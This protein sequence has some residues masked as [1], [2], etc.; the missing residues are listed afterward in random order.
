MDG[1]HQA[2]ANISENFWRYKI[3]GKFTTL[4]TTCLIKSEQKQQSFFVSISLF[5]KKL[6]TADHVT[7][8]VSEGQ[9]TAPPP[10]TTSQGHQNTVTKYTCTVRSRNSIH[11]K[12]IL[13]TIY[14]CTQTHRLNKSI[15]KPLSHPP[16]H[17][18][19]HTGSINQSINQ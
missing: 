7:I 15:N 1:L 11:T 6:C 8:S 16:H 19:R 14:K 10:P 17:L 3:S 12:V 9:I 5:C 13:L 4:V 2:F 18:H